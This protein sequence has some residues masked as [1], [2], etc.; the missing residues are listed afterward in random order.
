M[1]IAWET[2][3]VRLGLAW[4]CKKKVLMTEEESIS[5]MK[6]WKQMQFGFILVVEKKVRPRKKNQRKAEM[7]GDVCGKE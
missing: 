6:Y 2:S 7:W 3:R 1:E 5:G 4:L